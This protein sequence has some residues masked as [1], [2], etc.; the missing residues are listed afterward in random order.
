MRELTTN[1]VAQISGAGGDDL[2]YSLGE[3][4]G[5]SVASSQRNF[6]TWATGWAKQLVYT[7]A[8]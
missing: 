8:F 5:S 6:L 4:Y 1:E 2:A 3:A 7:R